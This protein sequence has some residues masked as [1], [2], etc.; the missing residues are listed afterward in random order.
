MERGSDKHSP[1]LDDQ[2][3]HETEGLVRGGK[4]TRAEEWHS[5]EPSGEDQPEVDQAPNTTLHGGT[6]AGMTDADVEGR[7]EL[8]RYLGASVYPAVADQ[9]LRHAQDANAPD[10]VLERI[11]SLPSGHP[12]DNVNEVWQ[13][14]GGA[15]ETQRF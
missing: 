3:Q 15:T 12:F 1:R 2:L 5:A 6:P 13:A 14:L 4:D 10:S 7:S 9:L 11:R 8:A